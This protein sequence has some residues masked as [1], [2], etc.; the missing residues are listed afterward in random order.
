MTTAPI[1]PASLLALTV[2]LTVV[3]AG[4]GADNGPST[5]ADPTTQPLVEAP[6]VPIRVPAARGPV[7]S[8]NLATV[9]DTGAGAELCLGAI[10]ESYPPQCSGPTIS[11]WNWSDHA[12]TFEKQGR[13]R[14]A[15]YAVSGSW[16]GT[17]FTVADAISGALYDPAAAQPT[18]LPS[19]SR[20]HSAAELDDIA[21]AVGADLPGAGA[22]YADQLGHVLVD[23]TYDDGTLQDYVDT[24]YGAGV[25]VVTGQ[26]VDAS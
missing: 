14:W 12:G 23:V 9:M 26:L 3:L 21:T 4:C 7:R 16:D 17:V 6:A 18:V 1:G 19:P 11:G 24:A 25:V 13:T 15:T 20:D 2:A 22:G 10:A 8:R 5:A